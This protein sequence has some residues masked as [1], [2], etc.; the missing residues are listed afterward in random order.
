M[1]ETKRSVSRRNSSES[2]GLRSA[3]GIERRKAQDRERKRRRYATDAAFRAKEIERRRKHAEAHPDNEKRR[4]QA[5]YANNKE[6]EIA[7][8]KEWTRQNKARQLET[9]RKYY[10]A[11][12]DRLKELIRENRKRRNPTIGLE[13][14]IQDCIA[15]RI[16]VD[17]LVRQYGIALVRLDARVN[18]EQTASRHSKVQPRRSERGLQLCKKH[19]G[20]NEIKTRR[21]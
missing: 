11:N 16:T 9:Q 2:S 15:G 5:Y 17:E 19:S 18:R 20:N 4:S 3:E 7:D 14:A 8:R 13:R 12:K 6:R 1:A 21:A 10:A